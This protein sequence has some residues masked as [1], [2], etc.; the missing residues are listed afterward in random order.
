M[1]FG[2][3]NARSLYRA[4]SL[5]TVV[6]EISQCKLDLVGLQ[7]VGWNRG[8]MEPAGQYIFFYGKGT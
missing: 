5:I 8:G 2:T 1:I 4:G 3:W 7:E 6:E